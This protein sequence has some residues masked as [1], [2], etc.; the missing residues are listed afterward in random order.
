MIWFWINFLMKI[1]WNIYYFVLKDIYMVNRD[2]Y[3]RIIFCCMFDID[4]NVM[5]VCILYLI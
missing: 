4:I 3:V 1:N 5:Y 2:V